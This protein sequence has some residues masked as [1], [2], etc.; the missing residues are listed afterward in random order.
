M[1]VKNESNKENCLNVKVRRKMKNSFAP[2]DYMKVVNIYD[3][4]DL[5]LLF[6]DLDA[7]FSCPIDKAFRKYKEKKTKAFPF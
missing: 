2:N 6:E 1:I 5:A 4:N 3:S 7:L